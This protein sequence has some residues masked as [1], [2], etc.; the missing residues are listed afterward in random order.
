MS[1]LYIANLTPANVAPV[2]AS[3]LIN[4][5]DGLSS[6]VNF[7]VFP[8]TVYFSSI[9]SMFNK[10]KVLS[11][12]STLNLISFTFAYPSGANTS[13]NVYVAS[14]SFPSMYWY[15]LSIVTVP[16]PSVIYSPISSS[17]LYNLNFAPDKYVT[18]VSANAVSA[19]AFSSSSLT[20]ASVVFFTFI[21]CKLYVGIFSSSM[22]NVI[23]GIL[24]S[25]V[26]LWS[27]IVPLVVCII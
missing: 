1:T 9:P 4:L 15:K 27:F 3:F 7:T 12:F 22:F 18:S 16:F 24:S 13:F 6:I 26:V 21:I 10:L 17:F 8:S 20:V 23:V 14:S 11:L 5:N 2:S 25:S 19:F